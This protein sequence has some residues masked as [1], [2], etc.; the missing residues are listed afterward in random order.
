M[1]HKHIITILLFI[2]ILIFTSC[3]GK[4]SKTD[5]SNKAAKKIDTAANKS[6]NLETSIKLSGKSSPDSNTSAKEKIE[7]PQ[8]TIAAA[9]TGKTD[10]VK[11][12]VK[13]TD[14]NQ[15]VKTNSSKKV[16][17]IDPG[18][19][20]VPSSEK[21]P[22]SPGSNV[23]KAKDTMGACGINSKLPEYKL[24]L[25]VAFKLEKL[26]ENNGF[27]VILTRNSNSQDLSNIERAEIGNKNNADLVIR[28]HGDSFS[29]SNVSGATMLVPGSCGYAKNIYQKSS[30]YGKVILN[31]L[32]K[33][34]G[35]KSRGT[36]VRC[37]LTGFN[38]SRVPVVLIEMGFLSNPNE[39]KLLSSDAYQ[40]KIANG[41]CRGI[42]KALN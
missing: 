24:N 18:H 15:A 9:S 27:K 39:D 14:K 2:F 28:I 19:S 37:D 41:L 25:M 33:T 26:L 8:K 5:T 7:A 31:E 12:S 23:M 4:I 22:I 10:K 11:A 1:K 29:D 36:K 13:T 35:M 32:I 3:S 16:I 40:N 21:E 38:W 20:S 6:D 17:V 42:C 34:A 30:T